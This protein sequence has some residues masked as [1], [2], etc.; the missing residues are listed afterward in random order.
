M[1]ILKH[2]FLYIVLLF[3]ISTGV[4]ADDSDKK[5]CHYKDG[6]KYHEKM[7]KK[8]GMCKQR[9][10]HKMFGGPMMRMGPPPMMGMGGP[11]AMIEAQGRLFLY[12]KKNGNVWTC[13]AFKKIC[14]QLVVENKDID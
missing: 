3:I 12:N 11:F 2:L 9:P 8:K 4:Y 13:N 10:M 5:I 1:N 14:E 6:K 7:W